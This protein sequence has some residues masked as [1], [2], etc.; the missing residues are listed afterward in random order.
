MDYCM[1]KSRESLVSLLALSV[2]AHFDL[3]QEASAYFST[4]L[5]TAVIC[6]PSVLRFFSSGGLA[7]RFDDVNRVDDVDVRKTHEQ[8]EDAA[9][10]ASASVQDMLPLSQEC[11]AC[12]KSHSLPSAEMVR[13]LINRTPTNESLLYAEYLQGSQPRRSVFTAWRSQ[14]QRRCT[15]QIVQLMVET[16]RY[17]RVQQDAFLGD[18]CA[19]AQREENSAGD[20]PCNQR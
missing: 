1:T 9:A 20:N 2:L 15:L 7:D 18:P 17:R 8:K 16:R 3:F 6:C 12:S 19:E 4:F 11:T 5:V 13:K 14:H 10:L